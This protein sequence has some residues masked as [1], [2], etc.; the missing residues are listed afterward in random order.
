MIAT[1]KT[2]TARVI[3]A[4]AIAFLVPLMSHAQDTTFPL[5]EATLKG[6][7]IIVSPYGTIELQD[8]YVT[9][10]SSQL[11]FD[12]MDLQRASQAYIWSTPLVGMVTWR[13]EQ[14]KQY[15]PNA[16]GSFAGL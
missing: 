11:L 12:A 15:G 10:R 3:A 9:D 8:N 7:E 16:R 2:T 13:I 14:N 6:D 4:A 1:I 5:Q